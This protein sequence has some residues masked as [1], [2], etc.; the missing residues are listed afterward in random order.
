MIGHGAIVGLQEVNFEVGDASLA[1]T[2]HFLLL[3]C[4][5]KLTTP[6]SFSVS[7]ISPL[8]RCMTA[9][10]LEKSS[11][12]VITVKIVGHVRFSMHV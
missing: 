7:E 10:D 2:D 9:C 5:N 3:P 12:F 8:L 4:S 1:V 11:I 6:A